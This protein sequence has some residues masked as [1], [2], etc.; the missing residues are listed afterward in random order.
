MPACVGVAA[1]VLIA[2]SAIGANRS[3]AVVSLAAG[4]SVV[5]VPERV[6]SE[7]RVGV[8]QIVGEI[9]AAAQIVE[10]VVAEVDGAGTGPGVD[11]AVVDVVVAAACC[12]GGGDGD[13]TPG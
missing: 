1:E 2:A 4:I 7:T 3:E 5:S 11:A 12:G 9:V 6:V 10:L 8:Q 13:V